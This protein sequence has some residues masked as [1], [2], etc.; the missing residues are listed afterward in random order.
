MATV[1]HFYIVWQRFI[2][3]WAFNCTGENVEEDYSW[4]K[5]KVQKKSN[6]CRPIIANIEILL[7]RNQQKFNEE[8]LILFLKL[9]LRTSWRY[10]NWITETSDALST[11]AMR[12]ISSRWNE[13]WTAACGAKLRLQFHHVVVLVSCKNNVHLRY[14][15]Q[16]VLIY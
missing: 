2:N 1:S 5:R 7:K 4:K 13:K 3:S 6:I 8:G 15:T 16:S 9:L 11:I 10:T 14:W 12:S